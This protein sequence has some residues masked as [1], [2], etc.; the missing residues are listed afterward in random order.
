MAGSCFQMKTD[1]KLRSVFF[2]KTVLRWIWMPYMNFTCDSI[3]TL[4]CWP[5]YLSKGSEYFRHR[6][7]SLLRLSDLSSHAS[8]HKKPKVRWKPCPKT[9]L[10]S[11]PAPVGFAPP[12]PFSCLLSV[13]VRNASY[14]AGLLKSHF[15]EVYPLWLWQVTLHSAQS[16]T[17]KC[18]ELQRF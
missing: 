15:I 11:T 9:T 16:H 2:F 5:F 6:S 4:F 18:W 12:P 17:N 14:A 13:R 7:H 3:L 8:L 10:S 1:Q